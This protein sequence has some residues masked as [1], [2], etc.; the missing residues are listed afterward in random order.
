MFFLTCLTEL[1]LVFAQKC[2]TNPKI[3]HLFPATNKTHLMQTRTNKHFPLCGIHCPIVTCRGTYT[4]QAL[5][6]SRA[7]KVD[8]KVLQEQFMCTSGTWCMH[9]INFSEIKNAF[10]FVILRFLEFFKTLL[11]NLY[12]KKR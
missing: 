7:R 4:Q 10:F 2:L 3:K 12:M 6:N 11:S 8:Q 9:L 1:C 5:S